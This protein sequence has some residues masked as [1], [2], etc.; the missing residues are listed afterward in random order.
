MGSNWTVQMGGSGASQMAATT[1]Q[2]P[3]ASAMGLNGSISP[4]IMLALV[5]FVILKLGK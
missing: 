4:L 3:T 5:A 2:T 1:T